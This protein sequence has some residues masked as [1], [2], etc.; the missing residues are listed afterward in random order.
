[1]I[2]ESN[3]ALNALREKYGL[4]EGKI[5]A[6][7][8]RFV[9]E[10]PDGSRVPLLPWRVERRFTELRNVVTDGTLEG[11]ST[12][13]S[14]RFSASAPL[15]ELLEKELDLIAFLAGSEIVSVFAVMTG[16]AVCNAVV[17]LANGVS[18][19]VECGTKLPAGR[20][21]LDRHELIAARGTAS[22]LTVDTQMRQKSVYLWNDA[23]EKSFTDT[24]M[25]LFGMTD[26]EIGTVRAAFAVLA[27]PQLGAAWKRA[28]A[29][30]TAAADAAF[31]AD[32]AQQPVTL[33]EGEEIR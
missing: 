15:R 10:Y 3:E 23:G 26:E 20:E 19:T 12:C 14:A 18:G 11:L 28:A 5:A 22:D 27:D 9:L 25:E 2:A 30:M 8:S 4:P 33:S 21:D 29:R 16:G 6:E 32:A 17:R 31:A 1:M 24:D 7:G 13:R